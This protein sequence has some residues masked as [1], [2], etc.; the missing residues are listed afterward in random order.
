MLGTP[1]SLLILGLAWGMATAAVGEAQDWVAAESVART[2]EVRDSALQN[3]Y[4]LKRDYTV[5][6]TDLDITLPVVTAAQQAELMPEE[7]ASPG[8]LQL[9]FGRELPAAY[10]GDLAPRLAWETRSD[11]TVVSALS[12]ESPG[13]RALR[14]A[15]RATLPDGGEIR[16]FSPA[17]PEERFRPVDRDDF[18]ASVEALD[19]E[20][21][22]ESWR[23]DRS[24]KERRQGWKSACPPQHRFRRCRFSSTGYHISSGPFRTP[25]PNGHS[26]LTTP[27]PAISTWRAEHA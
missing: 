21:G 1:R 7:P 23:G 11:G 16:F 13:A 19:Y 12:V 10:R 14:V 25:L 18:P 27:P 24:W 4:R 8:P 20:A 6:P 26:L 2:V 9:G 17:D 5:T 22:Q 3:R 15:L